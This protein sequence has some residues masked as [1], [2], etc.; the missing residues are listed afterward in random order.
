VT[1]VW[2]RA[3]PAAAAAA[4]LAAV[5]LLQSNG[6]WLH[7]FSVAVIGAV[8]ALGLQLLVGRAGLLSLGQGAFFGIGAYVAGWVSLNWGQP[9]LTALLLGGVGA[10]LSSLLLIP[11]VRLRGASL[12]VATLGFGIIVHLVLLNEV[13]TRGYVLGTGRIVLDGAGAAL[14]A[15]PQVWAS[16]LGAEQPEEADAVLIPS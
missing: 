1:A 6:Y 2:E 8:L 14:L 4:A 10:A 7:V 3:A 9:F 15:N 11:I 12:G 16:Y 13:A 5:P